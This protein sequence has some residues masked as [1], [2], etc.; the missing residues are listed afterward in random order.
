MVNTVK[1]SQFENGGD[2]KNSYTT[3]GLKSGSNAFF[4]NPWT[5]LPEGTT[6]SRPVPSPDI[7]YRLRLNTDT[8]VYEYY[9][10]VMGAWQQLSPNVGV[11]IWNDVLS[12]NVTVD[13]N[14][15]YVTNCG[16]SIVTYTLPA[17]AAFGSIVEILGTSADG[18]RIFYGSG[19]LIRLGEI[20][21]TITT[22]SISSTNR[23][24]SIKLICTV[25]NTT[26]QISSSVGNLNLV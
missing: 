6:I 12:P 17:T 7:N 15:G 21:T 24:D 16:S 4:N 5:F 22:G 13:V 18:W 1:F 9:N 3:V 11:Q 8:Q 20:A 19:Q 26:W 14:N 2:L 10:A 25:T 23:Y